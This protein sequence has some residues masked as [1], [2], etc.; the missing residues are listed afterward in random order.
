MKCTDYQFIR[1]RGRTRP[2]KSHVPLLPEEREET[3]SSPPS[4]YENHKIF[5]DIGRKEDTK[6]R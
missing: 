6:S 5:T 1:M 2:R 4:Y 3:F